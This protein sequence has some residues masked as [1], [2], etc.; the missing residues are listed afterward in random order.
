MNTAK[1]RSQRKKQTAPTDKIRE[2]FRSL[3]KSF[4]STRTL[5][6]G[7]FILDEFVWGKVTRISP[8]APVP[9]VNIER[10]SFVPG[11]ALNVA[12]NIRVLGGTVL[13]CGV[14]GKDLHGRLLTRKVREAGIDT[15]GVVHDKL[16]PTT[17][18]TRVVAHSQQVVRFDRE[19]PEEIGWQDEKHILN[20]VRREMKS[21]HCLVIEDYAK[22]V[23]TPALFKAVIALARK[24]GVTTVLDPKEKHFA[25]YQNVSVMTPNLSEAMTAARIGPEESKLPLEEVGRRLLRRFKCKAAVITLGEGG[26]CVAEQN[27][28]MTRIPT[29]ARE[30]FDV[31][32]AGDT[33]VAVIAMALGAGA[34]YIEA[35]TLAN[36]AAGIVVG[37]LGTATVSV[38]ELY[39]AVAGYAR[40]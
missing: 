4:P 9:V 6:I 12:N 28:N 8:E 13:P 37:K 40:Q 19:S 23:I 11:G 29:A 21:V 36:L 31:S 3:I 5:V 7:D 14:V 22:G 10:Q 26:M 24:Y 39:G 34:S 30:V 2:R 25:I 15:G 17:L 20:Y 33:V 32:G 16:R 38:D 35:A 1:V 27:G 18:K